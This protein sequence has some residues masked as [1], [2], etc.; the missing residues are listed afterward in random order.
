MTAIPVERHVHRSKR[1]TSAGA[2]AA[3]WFGLLGAH[4]AWSVQELV[5]YAVLSHA[6]FPR[7]RPL[8]SP[9]FD[10]TWTTSIVVGVA[11]L[12]AAVA[13][14][15]TSWRQWGRYRP[16]TAASWRDAL[17]RADDA[18]AYRYMAFWGV[19]AGGA[20]LLMIVLNLVTLFVLPTCGY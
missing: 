12:L 10:A 13:S 7:S 6:C 17:Q 4:V 14:V 1:P 15:W 3:L 11:M 8:V 5:M 19:A 9:I 2:W 20:F 18:R 16:E